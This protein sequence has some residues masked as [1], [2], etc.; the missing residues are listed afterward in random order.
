MSVISKLTSTKIKYLCLILLLG[1]TQ[2][3]GQVPE[4]E[5][6][7]DLGV[8]SYQ[9]NALKDIS[10]MAA[11]IKNKNVLWIHNDND[12]GT[13]YAINL[14]GKQLAAIKLASVR[15]QDIEDIAI[16]PGP[17]EG[18]DYIYLGDFG[19]NYS[20]RS[21]KYIYRFI[22]PEVREDQSYAEADISDIDILKFTYPG[23][24][25]NAETLIV[26]PLTSEIYIASKERQTTHI[27]KLNIPEASEEV[28]ELEFIAEVK[29][30]QAS[31]G[32]IS[33][34]G[35]EIVITNGRNVYYWKRAGDESLSAIFKR[36][37]ATI[38]YIREPQGEAISWSSD[39]AG[40][41]T[42]SEARGIQPHLYYY[43]AKTTAERGGRS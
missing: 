26:D 23:D 39:D 15:C 1:T 40:Y 14:Q 7:M 10:G 38:K 43:P 11:S 37:P 34:S 12:D 5:D 42:T 9:P 35:K 4:F 8:I 6:R 17:E 20:R 18:K 2:L 27:Y 41:F 24:E 30:S 21:I 33:T 36:L 25:R 13:A 22:E 28:T 32:N 31:G 16:G 29:I 3:F 19:D